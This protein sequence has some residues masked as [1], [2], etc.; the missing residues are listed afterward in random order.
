MGGK[1]TK[2]SSTQIVLLS[3]FPNGLTAAVSDVI[4]LPDIRYTYC[5]LESQEKNCRC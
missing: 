4:S 1:N 3:Y 5:S 2:K